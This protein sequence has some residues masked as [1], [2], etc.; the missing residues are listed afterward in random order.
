MKCVGELFLSVFHK[1]NICPW[2]ESFPSHLAGSETE[3]LRI[4]RRAQPTETNRTDEACS[5]VSRSTENTDVDERSLFRKVSVIISP[6]V[7]LQFMYTVCVTYRARSVR[8]RRHLHIDCVTLVH[9]EQKK[10]KQLKSHDSGFSSCLS[11]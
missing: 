3:R 4:Q 7:S 6:A 8:I 11:A 5:R 1:V 9:E 10:N 2:N